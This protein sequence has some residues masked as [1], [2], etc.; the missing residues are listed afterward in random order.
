MH[1]L[2]VPIVI[3]AS[4]PLCGVWCNKPRTDNGANNEKAA[5]TT[6]IQQLFPWLV[7]VSDAMHIALYTG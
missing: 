4:K 6:M 3:T 5:V 7:V 1:S 2:I